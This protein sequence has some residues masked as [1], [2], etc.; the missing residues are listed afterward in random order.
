MQKIDSRRLR[1][2]MAKEQDTQRF[3]HTLGVAYTATALAMRYGAD[4]KNAEIAGLLHDCAKCIPDERLLLICRKHNIT[5]N[6]YEQESPYLLHAKVGSFFAMEEYRVTDNDIINAIL[7]HI[8]GRPGMT[9]LEK[10]IYVADY[11]EPSRNKAPRLD[12]IRKTAF[13][14]LDQA[15]L[16]ILEDTKE[17]VQKT[18]R[19]FDPISE[20][21]QE[22]FANLLEKNI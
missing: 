22:Y 19:V 4:I 8:T 10:I 7:N 2:A 15:V 9:L 20:K 13:I 12:E 3:E 18:G 14:D 5:M 1:K 17:H 11:I 6:E 21:T 16:W